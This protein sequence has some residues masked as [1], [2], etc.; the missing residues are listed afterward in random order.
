MPLRRVKKGLRG[1]LPA[2]LGPVIKPPEV[3]YHHEVYTGF[4]WNL[5]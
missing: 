2:L 5:F 1:P 4:L 3:Q